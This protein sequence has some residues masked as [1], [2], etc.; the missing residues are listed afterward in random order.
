MHQLYAKTANLTQT[1]V[2]TDLLP[3]HGEPKKH[4]SRKW[5]WWAV[6]QSAITAKQTGERETANGYVTFFFWNVT[7]MGKAGAGVETRSQRLIDAAGGAA[8]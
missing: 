6:H 4:G 8:C 5:A 2:T 3:R 7:R 1:V